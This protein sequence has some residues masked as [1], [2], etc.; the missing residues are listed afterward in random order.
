MV[1]GIPL[2]IRNLNSYLGFCSNSDQVCGLG[3]SFK[4]H[5]DMEGG[6]AGAERETDRD[7]ASTSAVRIV[8]KEAIESQLL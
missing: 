3:A 6:G 7:R 4:V 8:K 2:E 5:G 1:P